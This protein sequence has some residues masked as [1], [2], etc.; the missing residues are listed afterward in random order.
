MSSATATEYLVSGS[1][2]TAPAP[3]S[4]MGLTGVLLSLAFITVNP[5]LERTPSLGTPVVAEQGS[6]ILPPHL[7]S[8]TLSSAPAPVAGDDQAGPTIPTYFDYFYERI[9]LIPNGNINLGVVVGTLITDATIWNAYTGLTVTVTDLPLTGSANTTKD[10]APG[11][12]YAL[13]PL[14]TV[15]FDL[16]TSAATTDFSFTTTLTVVESTSQAPF[17]TLTGLASLVLNLKPERPLRTMLEW[18][19]N[20]LTSN[21]GKEQRQS[22]RSLPREKFDL[23]Y[24]PLNIPERNVLRNQLMSHQNKAFGLPVWMEERPL[25]L[26]AVSADTVIFLDTSYARFAVGDPVIIWASENNYAVNQIDT[27][28][29]DRLTLSRPLGAD[30]DAGM[31][32]MPMVS[33]QVLGDVSGQNISPQFEHPQVTLSLTQQ[34][35][36]PSYTP[37]FTHEGEPLFLTRPNANRPLRLD[38][39]IDQ[40]TIDYGLGKFTRDPQWINPKDT[41]EH[42]F[43]FRTQAELW[44]FRKFM[45]WL[46]GRYETF[47]MPTFQDDLVQ[48]VA[49]GSSDTAIDMDNTGYASLIYQ[50]TTRW[51]DLAFMLPDGSY[52]TR[53]VTGATTESSTIDRVQL[54]TPL[55]VGYDPGD[56]QISFLRRV[57]V[58]SDRVEVDHQR[59]NRSVVSL[60]LTS[61]DE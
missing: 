40:R 16:V 43:V 44:E 1:L 15:D 10:G 27:I 57:R 17:L 51:R 54:S 23:R 35:P 34:L 8:G 29:A 26:D 6:Y 25:D 39:E 31:K 13:N 4:G 7:L 45:F 24:K 60:L 3:I 49:S 14:T 61:V 59:D 9:H 30:F 12:P 41:R 22:L 53:R 28:A 50:N 20:I 2:A 11:L 19:T 46:R 33:G 52:T 37:P 32:V 36:M 21:N 5:D 42:R 48:A 38:Q 47:Y 56:L 55:D 58:A 18:A